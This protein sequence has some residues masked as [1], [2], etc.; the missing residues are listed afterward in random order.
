MQID[1]PLRISFM[2]SSQSKGIRKVHTVGH[3]FQTRQNILRSCD[4]VIPFKIENTLKK[5]NRHRFSHLDGSVQFEI[6]TS[7][8]TQTTF[9]VQT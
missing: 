6:A 2:S 5:R 8:T 9:I 1:T 3:V 7:T 4:V